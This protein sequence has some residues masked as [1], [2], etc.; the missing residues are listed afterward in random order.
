M[1]LPKI[2]TPKYDM[3]VPSTGEK[4]TYRP[5]L[6]KEEKILMIALESEDDAQIERAILDILTACFVMKTKPSELTVFDVEYMFLML[7]SVS[8][9]ETVQLTPKC[10][11]CEEP[12]EVSIDLSKVEVK[13]LKKGQ[14]LNKQIKL[15]DDL[16]VDMHYP[17]VGDAIQA[18]TGTD[19]ILGTVAKCLDTIYYGEDTYNLVDSSEEE[20]VDFIENLNTHQFQKIAEILTE[21]PYVGKNLKWKCEECGEQ[22]DIEL[23]GLTD[24]F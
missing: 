5:Y 7:R 21:A 4:V 3:I 10:T 24:F 16:T 11:K 14:E 19:T 12:G 8:V 17:R 13:G 2:A 18:D 15:S 6:I 20:V 9:G 23:K 22:N 1:M